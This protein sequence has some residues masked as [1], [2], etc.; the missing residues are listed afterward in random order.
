MADVATNH[1]KAKA[2]QLLH[3]AF[4]FYFDAAEGAIEFPSTGIF[5]GI[6]AFRKM[7]NEVLP[8]EI[9]KNQRIVPKD[10]SD[11]RLAMQDILQNI[12]DPN[13]NFA[14]TTDVKSCVYCDFKAICNR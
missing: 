11:F 6:Y 7:K 8:L 13:Q 9:N 10:I 14:Q 1:Q 4:L 3:Y 12:Y 5:S 2:F